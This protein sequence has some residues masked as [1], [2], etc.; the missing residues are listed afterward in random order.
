MARSSLSSSY[1]FILVIFFSP[2]Y[3]SAK[4]DKNREISTP[5]YLKN[6]AGTIFPAPF[7][8]LRKQT[9]WSPKVSAE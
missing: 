6:N 5:A 2:T 1:T 8:L 3:I 9:W 7:L 4:I